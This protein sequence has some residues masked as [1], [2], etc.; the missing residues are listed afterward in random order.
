MI[1]ALSVSASGLRHADARQRAAAHDAA[2]A[3][4]PDTAVLRAAGRPAADGR[5]VETRMEATVQHRPAAAPVAPP[6]AGDAVDVM[7]GQVATGAA[8]RA[9]AAAV[10][11][12]DD[13]LGALLDAVG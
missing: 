3:S 5:G 12:A 13:M 4:T 10:R 11:T 1:D 8:A 2:N 6:G 9:G 7:A